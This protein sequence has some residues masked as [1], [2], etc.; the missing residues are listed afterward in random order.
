MGVPSLPQ[1]TSKL[2]VWTGRKIAIRNEKDHHEIPTINVIV[3]GGV[4]QEDHMVILTMPIQ[5]LRW[6]K[7]HNNCCGLPC[8]EV[9]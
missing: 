2:L 5:V 4:V 9:S 6:S 3:D 1:P 8:K 7:Q